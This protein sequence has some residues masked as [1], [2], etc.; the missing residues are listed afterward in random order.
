MKVNYEDLIQRKKVEME[1]LLEK[2]KNL[3]T[4]IS[5]LEKC[6]KKNK[7][8]K[9]KKKIDDLERLYTK[10]RFRNKSYEDLIAYIIS[11]KKSY[12]EEILSVYDRSF[13]L[14]IIKNIPRKSKGRPKSA[15][16]K[17][18]SKEYVMKTNKN[19]VSDLRNVVDIS[20]YKLC[21]DGWYFKKYKTFYR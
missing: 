18:L 21:V 12:N 4:Q 15:P 13:L 14:E 16:K 20:D 7:K 17:E 11:K 10:K 6:E 19:A 1:E 9:E 8:R 3:K 2:Q 5:D